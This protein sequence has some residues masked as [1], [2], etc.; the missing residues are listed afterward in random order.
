MRYLLFLSICCFSK[1]FAQ[2]ADT[3]LVRNGAPKVFINCDGCDIQYLKNEIAY[4]NFVRDRRLA[5]IVVLIRSIDTGNGGTEY[6]LPAPEK[7][8]T[9]E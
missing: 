4:L 7:M 1:L 9:K 2:D 6:T 3:T 8:I 5:D